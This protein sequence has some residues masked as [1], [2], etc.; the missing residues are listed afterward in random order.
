VSRRDEEFIVHLL[1]K[2]ITMSVETVKLVEELAQK[3]KQEDWL[4]K[5][6]VEV[7]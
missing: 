5:G 3:V 4:D 2:A 6:Q 1:G 7:S